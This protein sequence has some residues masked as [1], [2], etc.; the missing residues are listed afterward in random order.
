MV[1]VAS[2]ETTCGQVDEVLPHLELD[3]P[4]LLLGEIERAG[5]HRL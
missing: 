2:C 4:A 3:A 1:A 5:D